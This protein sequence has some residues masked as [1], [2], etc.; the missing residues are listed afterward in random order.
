MRD[1][2]WARQGSGLE[3]GVGDA[4]KLVELLHLRLETCMAVG[5]SGATEFQILS[6]VT[7]LDCAADIM[8]DGLTIVHSLT[9]YLVQ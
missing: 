1:T 7:V 5:I 4:G 3:E 9:M 2:S 6:M 8:V